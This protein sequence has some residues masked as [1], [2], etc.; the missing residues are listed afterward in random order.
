MRRRRRRLSNSSDSSDV[1]DVSDL[2][3]GMWMYLNL[4]C[5]WESQCFLSLFSPKSLPL[6]KWEIY[7]GNNFQY[8]FVW[9]F[10][11]KFQFILWPLYIFTLKLEFSILWFLYGL[12]A[13]FPF[14]GPC[15]IKKFWILNTSSDSWIWKICTKAL[16]S[17]NHAVCFNKT[18]CN[19]TQV[20]ILQ[21]YF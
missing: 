8:N 4:L 19:Y 16:V 17:L 9:V 14:H 1:S 12:D 18:I 10:F 21:I 11:K 20:D 3:E 6:Y 2:S 15:R 13:N 7:W 5:W